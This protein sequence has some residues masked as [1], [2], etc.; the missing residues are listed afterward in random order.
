MSMGHAR[1]ALGVQLATRERGNPVARGI[2]FG[3]CLRAP[4]GQ[5]R[6]ARRRRKTSSA[7]VGFSGRW[8]G[9][10]DFGASSLAAWVQA[11]PTGPRTRALTDSRLW[12]PGLASLAR[13]R[14]PP[15]RESPQETV[16]T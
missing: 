1:A 16:F 7:L 10:G 15:Q 11:V 6:G 12:G 13:F 2:A 4:V 9:R 8:I 5:T 3:C 14:V